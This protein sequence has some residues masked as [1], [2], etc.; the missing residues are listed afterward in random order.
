MNI[1]PLLKFSAILKSIHWTTLSHAYHVELN[2]AYDDIDELIDELVETQIGVTNPSSYE[3][4]KINFSIP[5]GKEHIIN[6]LENEI[7]IFLNSLSDY[8]RTIVDDVIRRVNR[9]MYFLRMNV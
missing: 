7:E 3:D 9:L 2:S 4:V 8:D 5:M 1:S 6:F